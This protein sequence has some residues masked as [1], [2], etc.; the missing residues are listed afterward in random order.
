MDIAQIQEDLGTW[1]RS[2][3]LVF[4]WEDRP[5][6]ML[7]FPRAILAGPHVITQLGQDWVQDADGPSSTSIPTV[8]G[9]RELT[10]TIRV[11]NRSQAGNSLGQ[12]WC[13]KLRASLKK[14]SVLLHFEASNI[15]IVRMG[16]TSRVVPEPVDGRV[17]SAASVEL[18]IATTIAEA[19]SA[20]SVIDTVEVVSRVEDPSGDVLPT[21]PNFDVTVGE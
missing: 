21:P 8:V 12:F 2:Q 5:Q 9:N 14:P 10:F 7:T 13:E 1:V 4:M 17:E 3:G 20:V 6:T 19:D 18:R 15:A 16:P 11:V